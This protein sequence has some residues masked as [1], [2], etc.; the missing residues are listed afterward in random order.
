MGFVLLWS[1]LNC[2][3]HSIFEF[4]WVVQIKFA[5]NCF[6]LLVIGVFV[7]L[8]GISSLTTYPGWFHHWAEEILPGIQCNALTEQGLKK[9]W[10]IEWKS[11][12]RGEDVKAREDLKWSERNQFV[13]F[14]Y[15]FFSVAEKM[16]FSMYG[17]GRRDWYNTPWKDSRDTWGQYVYPMSCNLFLQDDHS[18]SMKWEDLGSAEGQRC[19]CLQMIIQWFQ[20]ISFRWEH[21]DLG[22]VADHCWYDSSGKKLGG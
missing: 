4:W 18:L 14:I 20:P 5:N 22:P 21:I 6:C 3:R 17:P 1:Y 7:Y 11:L 15:V 9:I 8:E 16:I 19:V 13:S 12:W 2:T 10:S